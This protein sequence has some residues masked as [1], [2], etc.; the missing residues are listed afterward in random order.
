MRVLAG[1]IGGTNA[2]LAIVEVTGQAARIERQ[3]RYASDQ[4]PGLVAIVERFMSDVTVPPVRACFGV[5]C[6]VIQGV[7]RSANL[8]WTIEESQLADAIGISGTSIINDFD[9]IGHG[10]PFLGKGDVETLQKGQPVAHEPIALIG[11]G[12]G[13]GEAMLIWDGT[14]YLVKPSEGGHVNFAARNEVEWGLYRA[15]RAEFEHVSYERVVSGPGLVRIYRYLAAT[16]GHENIVVRHEM[17]REDPS[18]V[19]IRHGIAGSDALCEEA[20]DLFTSLL[21]AQAGNLALTVLALGGVYV[22]GGIAPRMISK[23]RTG[24]FLSS[25]RDKGRLSPFVARVPVHVI[26]NTNVGLLGAAGFA[27]A[28]RPPAEA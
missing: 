5:A 23:L 22:A 14:R 19:I 4:A 12:T 2:R 20:V 7:C 18:A 21:G 16:R 1:D 24:P 6:R 13:L 26:L 15:I 9:A 27:A 3:Q 10:L 28:H 8:P 25:F 11:A 17:S